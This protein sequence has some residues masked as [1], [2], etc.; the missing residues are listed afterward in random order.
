MTRVRS[1][2]SSTVTLRVLPLPRLWYLDSSADRVPG[3]SRAIRAGW[4]ML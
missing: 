1:P 3:R 2:A 4:S